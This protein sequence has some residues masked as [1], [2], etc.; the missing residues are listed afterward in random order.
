MSGPCLSEGFAK[1]HRSGID[2]IEGAGLSMHRDE[3]AS[4]GG[5]VNLRWDAAAFL[6]REKDVVFLEFELS[7][8]NAGFGRHQNDA[9]TLMCAFKAVPIHVTGEICHVFIIHGRAIHFTF[10]PEEAAGFDNV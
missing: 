8:G 5:R 6:T 2:N 1:N 9:R 4:I 3:N 7:V 10:A